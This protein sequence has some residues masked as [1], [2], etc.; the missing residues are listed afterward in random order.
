MGGVQGSLRPMKDSRQPLLSRIA[1][2][3]LTGSAGRFTAFAVD[4]GVAAS[5]YW[6]RRL[7]GKETPW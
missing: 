5:R 7:A 3:L 2:G 1:A 4:L 6:S